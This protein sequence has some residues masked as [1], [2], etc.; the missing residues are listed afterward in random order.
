[1]G[2]LNVTPDS[3]SDGGRYDSF[4]QA[5]DHARTMIE[6]GADI[7]DIGGEST[8][9]GAERVSPAIEMERVLPI[10]EALTDAGIPISVDTTRSITADAALRA[11]AC[12]INDV[13]G[14]LADPE[15]PNLIAE[16]GCGYI[17]MHWRG[18]SIDMDR[19]STY[20]D[21]VGEVV[22]ELQER[23]DAL[24]A[25]GIKSER[26]AIDPGLGF[27]KQ[28]EQN[29]ELLRGL[30]ALK[31]LNLPILIG[32][33]RKRFLGDLLKSQGADRPVDQREA[34]TLAISTLV[35]RQGVWAVRVHDVRSNRD[36][37]DVVQRWGR[38]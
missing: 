12:F 2:V 10:V 33:S 20:T 37:I 28:G 38:R 22:G 9:P 35:A 3:F 4:D 17:A 11:G 7:I 26:L 25:A 14:G 36:A 6:D 23:V 32:A 18:H 29:W 21:V 13:S 34:A 27:S 31:S 15:M 19:K 5:I 1:M 24:T 30:D 16:R 8:R